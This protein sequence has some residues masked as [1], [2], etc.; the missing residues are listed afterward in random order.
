MR[1][2]ITALI[3]CILMSLG[4]S[5]PLRVRVDE[6]S[7]ADSALAWER[8]K[9]L[10]VADQA[11][12]S[13]ILLQERAV[14]SLRVERSPHEGDAWRVAWGD[15]S[16]TYERLITLEDGGRRFRLSDPAA[17]TAEGH[18]GDARG[19]VVVFD[20]RS[21]D[22]RRGYSGGMDLLLHADGRWTLSGD[23]A[24]ELSTILRQLPGASGN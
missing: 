13:I 19:P 14:E 16:K 20:A 11:L 21:H 3:A 22:P 17:S 7:A 2:K 9:A 23:R 5:T 15:G 4:C 1:L 12:P 10:T 18:D 24:G 6:L 8:G